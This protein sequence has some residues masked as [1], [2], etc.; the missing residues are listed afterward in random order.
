[1]S[2]RKEDSTPDEEAPRRPAGVSVEE[3]TGLPWLRTWKAVYWFVLGCFA[4]CVGLLAALTVI[5]S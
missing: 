5:F 1:M 2:S 4:I 3:S